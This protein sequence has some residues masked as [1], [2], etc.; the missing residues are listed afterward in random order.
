MESNISSEGMV[1]IPLEALR[2]DPENPRLPAKLRGIKD[3]RVII[4]YLLRDEG[5][6]DLMRSIAESGY[7]KADPLLAVPIIPGKE[8]GFVVVEGNRRLAALK[9]LINPNLATVRK[10]S[11]QLISSEAKFKPQSI[12]VI[13]YNSRNDIIDYLGYKHITGVKEWDSMAK[14][15]YL[16]QLYNRHI[17]EIGPDTIYNVLAKMIGSRAGYVA[18]LHTALKLCEYANDNVYFNLPGITEDNIEFSLVTTALSYTNIVAYLGL[19]SAEDPSL[20]G[21]REEACK[22]LFEWMFVKNAQQVTRL[23][24]SRAL[25]ELSKVVSVPEALEQFKKGIPL[26]E[27]ILYTDEPIISFI[28]F[29][30]NAKDGLKNAINCLGKLSAPPDEAGDV[31]KEINNLIAALNGAAGIRASSLARESIPDITKDDIVKIKALLVS[32]EKGKTV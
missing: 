19:E 24:E 7:A 2:F 23:G 12:P 13:T 4:E 1:F 6:L 11:V 30:G 3:D 15:K 31:L 5:L 27:A 10:S 25:K 17:Q 14:A 16:D 28:N 22:D 29:L 9:L 32:M 20:L 8:A 26:E 18:R 21:M